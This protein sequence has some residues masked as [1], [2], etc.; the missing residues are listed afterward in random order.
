MNSTVNDKQFAFKPFFLDRAGVYD[1]RF[2]VL[3]GNKKCPGVDRDIKMH[4]KRR[5]RSLLSSI[6]IVCCLNLNSAVSRLQ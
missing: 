5:W 1:M 3:L 6:L 2:S 4:I